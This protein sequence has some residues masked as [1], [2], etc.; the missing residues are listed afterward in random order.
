MSEATGHTEQSGAQARNGVARHV[1][2]LR[3]RA[4][5]ALCTWRTE[6]LPGLP[7]QFKKAAPTSAF[8]IV[9]FWVTV[10]TFGI[11]HV[12]PVSCYTTLFNV[13]H[14]K[15][16]P[17]AQY[18][19]FYLVSLLALAAARLATLNL[20]LCAAL[21]L[22]MPFVFVFMRSSQL[23]PRRYFPYMMLFLFL[24]LRPEFL[25][26]LPQQVLLLLMCCT[27]LT[28]ALVIS[29]VVR[30]AADANV[31]KLHENIRRLA[32]VLQHMADHGIGP[33]TRPM[34]LKLRADFSDLAYAVREDSSVQPLIANLYEM[35]AMLTQRTAYLV[36]RL[37]WHEGPG[38]PHAPYLCE[39]AELTRAVDQQINVTDNRVLIRQAEQLAA[40]APSIANDRFRLFYRSY[41]RMLILILRDAASPHRHAWHLSTANQL[42]VAS[43][44]KHP[45]L[46]SFELRFTIRCAVIMAVSCTVSLAMPVDHLY[47]FP[48]TAFLLTQPWPAESIH[49]MRT[50]TAGTVLGCVFVHAVS[51]LGLPYAAVMLL[52]MVLITCLYSSTPGGTVMAFF[53]TAYALSMASISI[54]DRYAI[55]M[56][57]ACLAASVA[58][59]FAVN[60]RVVPTSD[61]RLF[62]ANAHQLFD[63]IERYWGLLRTSLT[64]DVDVAA[65]SEA[66]LHFQMVHGRAA[67]YLRSLPEGDEAGRRVKHA[68]RR[69][70]F[71][72]WE[73]MSELEQLGML[74]RSGEVSEAEYE[75]LGLF[76]VVA[77][78]HCVPFTY[79]ERMRPAELLADAFAE[80]D[81]RYVLGQYLERARALAAALKDARELIGER[82]RYVEEIRGEA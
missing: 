13:R 81:L 65:S 8:F 43:F 62:L 45:S 37:E 34:V 11:S 44:R 1:E 59:V 19:R 42:R 60:R 50:R 20:A 28:A 26:N 78:N 27:V 17:P 82:P 56:R 46:D 48:L 21:N 35:F 49:R 18:A 36:G 40:G 68:A 14:S 47:W 71:C 54:G 57:L 10:L 74:I 6:T 80:E 77:E 55:G 7:A 75:N 2:R 63:L 39:L 72:L 12:M 76:M 24:Q 51:L 25:D 9:L 3:E 64:S 70:L 30:H 79:D 58:L 29:G 69:V 15:Y 38:C 31:A 53:A 41:L 61:R 73:L 23:N 67:A 16:N 52:G 32:E 22:A 5:A 33:A 4:M 66:L